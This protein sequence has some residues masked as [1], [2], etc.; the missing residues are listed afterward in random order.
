MVEGSSTVSVISTS[1]FGPV[2]S[3]KFLDIQAPIECGF[4]LKHIREWIR[5]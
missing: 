4:S 3:E 5:T 2:S 1:D